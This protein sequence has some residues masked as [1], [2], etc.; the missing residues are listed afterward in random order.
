M[1]GRAGRPGQVEH[2]RGI[3]LIEKDF[4]DENTLADLK[5]ALQNGQGDRVMSRLPDS[6]DSLMRFLLAVTADR[7]ETTLND[8]AEA[9]R[10]TL[11]YHE[12]PQEIVFGRPFREDIMEDIPSFARV[13]SDM[14]VERAWPVTDGVAGSI[15]SGTS[16]YNFEVRFS[17]MDCTCQLKPSGSGKMYAS[18]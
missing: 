17:C 8:L 15:K 14:C 9:V 2:G 4:I 7:G 10:H 11:W 3:A 13:T 6:F 1:L 12:Q 18:I 5:V 16:L